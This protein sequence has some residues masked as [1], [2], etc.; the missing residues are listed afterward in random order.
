MQ[1]LLGID[2]RA[3]HYRSL[4]AGQCARLADDRV[5]G[6]GHG[7]AAVGNGSRRHLDVLADDD[8]AGPRIDDDLGSGLA[9]IDFQVFQNRQVVDTLARIKRRGHTHRTT[10]QG[11]SDARAQQFVDLVDN[12]L[13]SG[14]VGTVQVQ[15]Q[16]IA[17]IE[18]ARHRALDRSSARNASRRRDV[19]GNLRTVTAFR[20][21]TAD[22]QVA[23]S[24]GVNVA[25]DTF[26]RCHQQRTTAQAF[27]VTD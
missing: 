10:V 26:H 12:P 18:A 19:D 23:L 4:A 24:D 15:G 27:G 1:L 3:R 17:L 2:P 6:D 13:G 20:V 22:H 25:V 9:R 11:L 7:Q 8:G 14:E 21:E 16:G 5:F